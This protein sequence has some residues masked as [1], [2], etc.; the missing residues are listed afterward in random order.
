MLGIAQHAAG[1]ET[2]RNF[3]KI[4]GHKDI[5]MLKA[6]LDEGRSLSEESQIRVDNGRVAAYDTREGPPNRT[7]RAGHNPAFQLTGTAR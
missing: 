4:M 6:V 3:R 7:L 2:E 1:L 5:W